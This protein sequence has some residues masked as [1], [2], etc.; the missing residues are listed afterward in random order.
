MDESAFFITG[1]NGQLGRALQEKYPKARKATRQELDISDRKSVQDYDWSGVKVILNTASYNK[2][3]LAETAEGR[4]D[5]WRTNASAVANLVEIASK[6]DITLVHFSTDYVF[7]G[8]QKVHKEDE[9]LAPL[10]SYAASKAAGEIAAST[11]PK[12]YILRVMW[13]IGDGGNFVRI[14]L[15][16]GEKG[17]SPKVVNDQ[18]GR[19]TFTSEIVRAIDHLLTNNAEYGRYHVSNGGQPASWAGISRKIFQYGGYKDIK[20]TDTTTKE[21]FADKEYFAVRPLSSIFDL[22]KMEAAGFKFR[23]WQDDLK[24]YI[25]KEMKK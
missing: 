25:D 18:I 22:S 12:H 24:E 1:A 7:D 11:V 2:V 10:S 4:K 19:L 15:G 14:M 8:T 16:L 13:V 6:H 23:D 17:I 21:Y 9:P 20:V 5:A 3:D